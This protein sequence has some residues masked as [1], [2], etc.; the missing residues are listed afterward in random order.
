M[1]LSGLVIVFRTFLN[2][3]YII[4]TILSVSMPSLSRPG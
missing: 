2:F 4:Q 1:K 3:A